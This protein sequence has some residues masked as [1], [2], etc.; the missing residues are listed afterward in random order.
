MM[1]AP[2]PR[3]AQKKEGEGR[4]FSVPQGLVADLDRTPAFNRFGPA[5]LLSPT[6]SRRWVQ[7]RSGMS[8]LVRGSASHRFSFLPA[9]LLSWKNSASAA[10]GT[11]LGDE[12][13][14]IIIAIDA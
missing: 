13:W 9:R 3:T 2:P 1:T 8:R 6:C 14:E 11:T 4:N 10:A 5:S 12:C 7:A